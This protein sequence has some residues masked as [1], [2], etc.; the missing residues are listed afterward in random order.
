MSDEMNYLDLE[1]KN[2][3]VFRKMLRLKIVPQL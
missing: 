2:C 1:E 3:L